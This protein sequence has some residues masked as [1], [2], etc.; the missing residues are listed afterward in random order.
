MRNLPC[1]VVEPGGRSH[2]GANGLMYLLAFQICA[3]LVNSGHDLYN[4]KQF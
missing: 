2:H 1:P 3:G 4:P